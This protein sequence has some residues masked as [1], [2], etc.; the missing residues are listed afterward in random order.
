MT[1]PTFAVELAL[2]RAADEA[3]AIDVTGGRTDRQTHGHRDRFLDH[4]AHT[5]RAVSIKNDTCE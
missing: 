4:A 5:M 3:A 1:L 2:V